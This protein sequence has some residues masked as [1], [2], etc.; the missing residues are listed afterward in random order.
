MLAVVLGGILRPVSGTDFPHDAAA[1]LAHLTFLHQEA[2]PYRT[3]FGL[4]GI[5]WTM[6][7]AA[8]FYVAFGLVVRQ[9]L[10]HPY[11]WLAASV[12]VTIAWRESIA[13]SPDRLAGFYLQFPLFCADFGFGITGAYVY[14][15]LHRGELAVVRRAAPLLCG[16]FLLALVGLLYL[17]GLPVVRGENQPWAESAPLAVLIP[18]V[19]TG[20]LITMPFVPARLQWLAGNRLMCRIGDVSYALFLFH[21]LVIWSV[22]RVIHVP[23]NYSLTSTIELAAL[24]LPITLTAAWA[25]TRWVERPLRLRF[26]QFAARLDQRSASRRAAVAA[27]ATLAAAD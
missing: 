13:T 12:L 26:Q 21:F 1:V 2:Y 16:V 25:A 15:R 27:P 23:R 19:F 5:V 7:I 4:Q 14:T 3:G 18:L 10:R 6:S 9:W 17:A 8:V 24:V 22:L 11:L 20:F